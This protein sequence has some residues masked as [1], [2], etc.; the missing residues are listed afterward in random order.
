MLGISGPHPTALSWVFYIIAVIT[1]VLG[2]YLTVKTGR[3]VIYKLRAPKTLPA[4]YFFENFDGTPDFATSWPHR[5][6]LKH[7]IKVRPLVV[8]T[9]ICFIFA[10]SLYALAL[11]A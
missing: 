1:A 5:P 3:Q 9:S 7:E 11:V 10:F 4:S 8:G 2:L 6:A